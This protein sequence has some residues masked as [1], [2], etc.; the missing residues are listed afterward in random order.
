MEFCIRYRINFTRNILVEVFANSWQYYIFKSCHQFS[1]VGWLTKL[2]IN[3]LWYNFNLSFFSCNEFNWIAT[4]C[5]TSGKFDIFLN[6]I[7][8]FHPDIK[9]TKEQDNWIQ[10]LSLT[11]N[12]LNSTSDFSIF[13]ILS[14]SGIPLI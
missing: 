13:P 4:Y 5:G 7:I 3:L 1:N 12:K 14:H 2:I 11:T 10:F 6:F 9:I 8:T